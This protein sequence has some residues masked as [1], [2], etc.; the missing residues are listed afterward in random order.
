MTSLTVKKGKYGELYFK[1]EEIEKEHG[2]IKNLWMFSKMRIEDSGLQ[3]RVD[4][5]PQ[6]YVSRSPVDV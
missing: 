4:S 5:Y 2:L 1:K 3:N 6:G